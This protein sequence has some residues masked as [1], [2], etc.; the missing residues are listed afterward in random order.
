MAWRKRNLDMQ[1]VRPD[2]Q[3]PVQTRSV[4]TA[5]VRPHTSMVILAGRVE[6]VS[7]ERHGQHLA[8]EAQWPRAEAT[9]TGD[10]HDACTY[11][12]PAFTNASHKMQNDEAL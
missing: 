2:E 7:A 9:P 1:K 8:V 6:Q 11:T 5:C 10:V 12:G 4:P 3:P